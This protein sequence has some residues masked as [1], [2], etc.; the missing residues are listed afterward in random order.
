MFL[1]LFQF[2]PISQR[3]LEIICLNW[4]LVTKTVKLQFYRISCDVVCPRKS[5]EDSLVNCD[6][7]AG[8]S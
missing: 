8:E 6:I 4:H 7:R 2:L 3:N 5:N 1:C